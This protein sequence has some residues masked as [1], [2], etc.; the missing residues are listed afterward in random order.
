M[1]CQSLFS[2]K[3]RRNI[4][5]LLSDEFAYRVVTDKSFSSYISLDEKGIQI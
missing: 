1:K 4:T 2:L 3:N 5:N